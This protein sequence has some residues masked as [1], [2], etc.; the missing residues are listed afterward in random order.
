LILVAGRGRR[1]ASVWTDPK[2]LLEIDGAPLLGR[3][4]DV[5]GEFPA[6]DDICLVVGY[7]AD[8][9][10]ARLLSHPAT[11]RVRYVNNPR[12]ED[13]SILSLHAGLVADGAPTLLMDG[14]VYFEPEVV[15]RLLAAGGDT[16]LLVDTTSRNTG[17]EI[18]VGGDVDRLVRVGRGMSGAFPI[19]GEW[20]GF[21]TLAPEATHRFKRLADDRIIAGQ[22]GGGYEDVLDD[23]VRQVPARPCLVDG[24]RWIEIDFPDDVERARRLATASHPPLY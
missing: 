14:D 7:R 17:E 8:A 18:M 15:R 13:G 3:Y 20:I 16:T 21:M 19:Y 5:L 4:L 24:L 10:R 2:C 1:L 23:L 6:I 11:A 22:I 9:V 12:Y